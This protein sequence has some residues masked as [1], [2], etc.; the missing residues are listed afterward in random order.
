MKNIFMIVIVLMAL[1]ML[2]QVQIG[3]G[4][5]VSIGNGGT[6]QITPPASSSTALYFIDSGGHSMAT[7]TTGTPAL[8]TIQ[9][10]NNLMFSKS[11][12]SST[13]PFVPLVEGYTTWDGNAN[14]ETP[15]AGMANS[16]AASNPGARYIVGLHGYA[17]ASYV[18][19]KLG[20]PLY[21]L[22]LNQLANA[23]IG[24]AS[25]GY[26]FIPLASTLTMGESDW[27][28]GSTAIIS[29]SNPYTVY[30]ADLEAYQHDLLKSVR[31]AVP[32]VTKYPLF[33]AQANN[34]GTGEA[35]QSQWQTCKDN[36]ATIFCTCPKYQLAYN[37]GGLHLT[38]ISYKI[39]GE[40]YA[41][42]IQHW[43]TYGSW[44]PLQMSGATRTGST[45]IVSFNIPVPPLALDTTNI[46]AHANYG[47][48]WYDST[49]SATISS[50]SVG[51][52]RVTVKLSGTPT[53]ANQLLRY[54]WTCPAGIVG[55]S[56]G[57]TNPAASSSTTS[58]EGNIRDSDST[59]SPSSQG[60]ATPLYNWLLAGE[61]PLPSVPAAPRV[62]A[63]AGD[64]QAKVTFNL[65]GTSGYTITSVTATS[66][67]GSFTTSGTTSPL[68]VSG[69]TNGTAYTFKVVSTNAYGASAVATTNRVTP[70]APASTP[71]F[72]PAAGSYSGTQSV[73]ISAPSGGVI[74][75]NATGSPKTNGSTGCAVGTLYTGAIRV[76]G[77]ET[78]Y[79]IAGGTGY[80]DSTVSSAAYTITGVT[81]SFHQ[82]QRLNSC[83][84]KGTF[85][86]T[87]P[88]N[89][90]T[91]N[92]VVL[93]CYI[94]QYSATPITAPT[95][96]SGTSY[97]SPATG[98]FNFM[99][100]IVGGTG[101]TITFT[102]LPYS[103]CA[104]GEFSGI[105]ATA[106]EQNVGEVGGGWVGRTE[107]LLPV[108]T[109]GAHDVICASASS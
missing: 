102:S 39:I 99:G 105:A 12:T 44:T 7:G 15:S 45:V 24:A 33:M 80:S 68:T 14:V 43:V 9:P 109:T 101:N 29:T 32:G 59:V 77:S 56:C 70:H 82:V 6:L 65:A 36:P 41:K 67:P 98:S 54:A 58:I 35:A 71:A 72:S 22:F 63:A 64:A 74:C 75:Y 5:T 52:S 89:V 103:I 66:S 55:V 16:L 87:L 100:E 46:Y 51:A 81:H 47:F 86:C 20:T 62:S 38:D 18:S 8:S 50:V 97:I 26:T 17:G 84:G 61:V 49:S 34:T 42:A 69:L 60:T 106:P 31:A 10:Y 23:K 57:A 1:P 53:G 73:A 76:L 30:E 78:L 83:S 91:G 104:G 28:A 90:A 11:L 93:A 3:N 40:Y 48:E 94:N 107:N 92:V 88:N 19:I 13:L 79:A 2:A 21:S 108:T 85:N 25:A 27:V 95:M 37:P 4:G 96:P